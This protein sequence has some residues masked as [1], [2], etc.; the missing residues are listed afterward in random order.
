M[1]EQPQARAPRERLDADTLHGVCNRS[2]EAL[3]AFFA[4]FFDRAYGYV[5]TLVGNASLAEDLTQE[6]FLK[7]HRA[8]DRLDP[9]RDPA[10]WV[11]TVISN[12]VRDHFRSAAHR[13]S[14]TQV[15][16]DEAWNVPAEADAN[17]ETQ[18]ERS[19]R[20]SAVER[21]M[22]RLSPADREVLLLREWEQLT[23]SE[24]AAALGLRE[25]AVR[26]RYS[27]AVRRLARTYGAET[28]QVRGT[29]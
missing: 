6:A 16:L 5:A 29:K 11:F 10:P 23:T 27:R 20:R 8:I 2:P 4:H 15:D 25:D 12:T 7:M 17:P 22:Q 1:T 24:I 21:A 18:L 19:E 14:R 9:Q 26:Q 3:N 13:A 28:R